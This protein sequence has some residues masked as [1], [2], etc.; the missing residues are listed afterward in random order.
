MDGSYDSD[1]ANAMSDDACVP[2]S[3]SEKI[4]G[5]YA[6]KT[7]GELKASVPEGNLLATTLIDLGA[8]EY[9]FGLNQRRDGFVRYLELSLSID[10]V[11][12]ETAFCAGY[13]A[14]GAPCTSNG[15]PPA[16]ILGDWSRVE[17]YAEDLDLRLPKLGRASALAS[18]LSYRTLAQAFRKAI[19]SGQYRRHASLTEHDL[20][21]ALER[22][23]AWCLPK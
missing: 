11:V 14:I 7:L 22:H 21:A 6:P 2:T 4:L 16:I 8:P 12:H 9:F 23:F 13:L 20:M 10:G 3:L 17:L 18:S 15:F 1:K 19:L 5:E